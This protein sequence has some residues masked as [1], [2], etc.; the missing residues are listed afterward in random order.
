MKY[1]IEIQQVFGTAGVEFNDQAE[2]LEAG[3]G[4][5]PRGLASAKKAL[6]AQVDKYKNGAPHRIVAIDSDGS[7]TVVEVLAYES[8][9][10]KMIREDD[11]ARDA[12]VPVVTVAVPQ[13]EALKAVIKEGAEGYENGDS[14]ICCNPYPLGSARSSAY[15]KGWKE[16]QQKHW[17]KVNDKPAVE[18]RYV[19]V[20]FRG[21]VYPSWKVKDNTKPKTDRFR[22]LAEFKRERDADDFAAML[23][24]RP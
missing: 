12:T 6:V 8:P 17:D 2:W 3:A 19:V 11:A 5:R 18:K 7:R 10:A 20:L 24:A 9:L 15:V 4:L 1:R 23:E 13:L 14:L 22:V 21:G 16:A